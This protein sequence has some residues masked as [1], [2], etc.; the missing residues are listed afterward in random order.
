MDHLQKN[1]PTK[2]NTDEG[3]ASMEPPKPLLETDPPKTPPEKPP[4]EPPETL[5]HKK[6]I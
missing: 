4:F 1:D 3:N 2:P 5:K 6:A